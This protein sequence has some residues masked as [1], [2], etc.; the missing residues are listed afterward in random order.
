M[1]QHQ[2]DVFISYSRRDFDEVNTIV[3]RIKASVPGIQIWF[4][5]TGIESGD[6]FEDKI[7]NAIDNSR[8][9]LFA[10]SDNSI[11]S[12][13]AKDEVMYA[14]NSDKRVIPVLL[15]GAKLKGWFLF[16]FGR[17]D[18]IDAN[19]NLQWDKLIRDLSH[20]TN[21]DAENTE[22]IVFYQRG[23]SYY[24][25]KNYTEAVK[26]FKKAADLNYAPAQNDLGDCYWHGDGVNHDDS[27]AVKWY[28]KAAEQNYAE[29]QYSLGVNYYQGWGVIKDRKEAVKWFKKAIEQNYAPAQHFLGL[30]YYRGQ[31]VD[32]D[33]SEA[34]KWYRKAIE[35]NYAG[36][37][38]SLGECYEQGKGVNKNTQEAIKWYQAAAKQ[39][40]IGGKAALKRLGVL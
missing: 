23:K 39:G 26:W 8:I 4:D 6:E 32:Q 17:I 25:N 24:D 19:V 1:A 38:C 21:P 28:K 31:G 30:L 11:Q 40:H 7:I 15:K 35:Q 33:Y 34:V 27:E 13:W 5:I 37:Q 10:L 18:C 22:A 36:A 12:Q 2:Y 9:I 3:S 29:A 20:W 14:K 16:K